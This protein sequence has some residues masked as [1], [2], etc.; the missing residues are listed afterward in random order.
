[1]SFSDLDRTITVSWQVQANTG[2]Q[3]P[4]ILIRADSR[5]YFL[6]VQGIEQ[7]SGSQKLASSTGRGPDP[8]DV[9]GV[10]VFETDSLA[11]KPLLK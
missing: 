3:C 1:M 7:C 2:N 11:E 10:Q 6:K 9:P 4:M 5:G 8:D